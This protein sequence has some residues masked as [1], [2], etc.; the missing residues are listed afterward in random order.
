M[1]A[2]LQLGL[3]GALALLAA[4]GPGQ[5]ISDAGDLGDLGD[6]GDD[7]GTT[8]AATDTAGESAEIAREHAI[9]K[10]VTH[11]KVSVRADATGS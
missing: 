10:L 6:L 3:G 2:Q 9:A 1:R 7:E 4:C 11:A 5:P 8:A